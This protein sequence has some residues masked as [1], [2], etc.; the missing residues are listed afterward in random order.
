MSI[1]TKYFRGQG[2]VY[3]A[4]RT[5]G[6]LPKVLRNLG[7]VPELKISL[8]TETLEH[9]ESQSGHAL[10]D[11]RLEISKK[12]SASLILEHFSKENLALLVRSTIV[13]VSASTAHTGDVLGGGATDAVVG[14][15]L[16]LGYRNVTGVVI[17]D[18]TG[19]PKTLTLNVNYR[20]N[21]ALGQIELLDLTTGGAFVQPFKADFTPGN[22]T[23]VGMFTAAQKEWYLRFE[24][25]NTADSN[26]SVGIDLFRF[27]CDPSKELSVIGDDTAKFELSGSLLLDTTR[28]SSAA[29]GQFGAIFG[30]S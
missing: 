24:G 27:V 2:T 14:N 23:E 30:L 10:T 22:S 11:L 29:L 3:L 20:L 6:G 21:A 9:K 15:V 4:E 19:S 1:T 26:A 18:S 7:N 25:L 17:K 12:A 5:A 28:A 13:S 8:E 16:D